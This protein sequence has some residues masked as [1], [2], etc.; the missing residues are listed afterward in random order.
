MTELDHT[1]F[2]QKLVGGPV[3]ISATEYCRLARSFDDMI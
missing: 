1:Q 3:P 2:D